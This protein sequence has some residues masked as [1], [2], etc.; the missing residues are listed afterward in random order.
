VKVL[1]DEKDSSKW[2][3]YVRDFARNYGA[4]E[5]FRAYVEQLQAAGIDVNDWEDL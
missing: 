4:N 2:M 1:L 3:D 5:L